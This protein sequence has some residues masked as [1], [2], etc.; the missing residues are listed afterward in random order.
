VADHIL[1]TVKQNLLLQ[2]P[3]GL[4]D[5]NGIWEEPDAWKGNLL[6]TVAAIDQA[7]FYFQALDQNGTAVGERLSVTLAIDDKS[8]FNSKVLFRPGY[9][10]DPRYA[11]G[12]E[13][14]FDWETPHHAF[15]EG[16][17]GTGWAVFIPRIKKKHAVGFLICP[18]H[19]APQISEDELQNFDLTVVG[20]T[21]DKLRLS[22]MGRFF[23]GFGEGSAMA[24]LATTANIIPPSPFE[25]HSEKNYASV[26]ISY[27]S[28]KEIQPQINATAQAAELGIQAAAQLIKQNNSTRTQ[29]REAL[30]RI[31]EV[32]LDAPLKVGCKGRSCH[33]A[34]GSCY[35]VLRDSF[36]YEQIKRGEIVTEDLK[37]A[38]S[39]TKEQAKEE[40]ENPSKPAANNNREDLL[41]E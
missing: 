38:V 8:E 13:V 27:I 41:A 2:L 36:I 18:R 25:D 5:R 29:V 10:R 37:E 16:Q 19:Y 39:R 14:Y 30:Y 20:G 17:I 32:Y 11:G 9:V 12:V 31:R 23:I 24:W 26:E 28:S 6:E 22:A 35:A 7:T 33:V 40:P 3:Q 4:V 21:T 34:P 15:L 1:T